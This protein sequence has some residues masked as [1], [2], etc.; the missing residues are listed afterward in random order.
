M[1]KRLRKATRSFDK[2]LESLRPFLPKPDIRPP[3]PLKTWK[4]PQDRYDSGC[5]QHPQD[6]TV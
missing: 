5:A 4:I 6:V 2:M 1:H 3:R